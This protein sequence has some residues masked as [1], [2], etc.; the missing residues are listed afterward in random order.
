MQRRKKTKSAKISAGDCESGNK[1]SEVSGGQRN[2]RPSGDAIAGAAN[3][4]SC[5]QQT[6]R[7]HAV[8]GCTRLRQLLTNLAHLRNLVQQVADDRLWVQNLKNEVLTLQDENA[9]LQMALT[10]ELREGAHFFPAVF[11]L[12]NETEGRKRPPGMS[13]PRPVPWPSLHHAGHSQHGVHPAPPAAVPLYMD[14]IINAGVMRNASTFHPFIMPWNV[15]ESDIPYFEDFEE[16]QQ[17]ISYRGSSPIENCIDGYSALPSLL[18]SGGAV[19]ALGTDPPIHAQRFQSEHRQCQQAER[20][21]PQLH[22]QLELGEHEEQVAERPAPRHQ[23]QHQLERQQRQQKQRFL[24]QQQR[25]LFGYPRM[26][27]QEQSEPGRAAAND[28]EQEQRMGQDC[29]SQGDDV[30][31]SNQR[32][33]SNPAY[34]EYEQLP[35]D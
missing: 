30:T 17:F 7:G 28:A 5:G 21:Q 2:R 4:S 31:D 24:L 14:E 20:E 10:R 23:Q 34:L 33:G 11:S 8:N 27:R 3:A 6:P 22:R 32:S 16:L 25:S 13:P 15:N 26:R 18:S 35:L 1:D 12:W 9:Q 19:E 29:G